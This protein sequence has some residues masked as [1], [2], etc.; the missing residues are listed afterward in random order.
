MDVVVDELRFLACG[1]GS[2]KV[3]QQDPVQSPL[4]FVVVNVH[5]LV[6]VS[7]NSITGG[8]PR[9]VKPRDFHSPTVTTGECNHVTTCAVKQFGTWTSRKAWHV[10]IHTRQICGGEVVGDRGAEQPLT[11]EELQRLAGIK[12]R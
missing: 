12:I 11:I 6:V 5:V 9:N 10:Q 8:T 7:P 1:D 2:R 4:D 3:R